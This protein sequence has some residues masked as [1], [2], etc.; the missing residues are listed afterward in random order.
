MSQ[1][2]SDPYSVLGVPADAT[3]EQIRKAYRRKARATHPDQGGS[4]PEFHE[5]SEA[6]RLL[7]DSSLKQT[8][9]H[10]SSN[11]SAPQATPTRPG[12]TQATRSPTRP[13]ARVFSTTPTFR[14]PFDPNTP[15]IVPLV[16]AGQQS[17]SA[18]RRPSMLARLS[19]TKLA[20][21]D[22]EERTAQLLE[23]TILKDYP[24]GRLINGVQFQNGTEAGSILLG[25]YRVAVV[26]SLIASA[27]A[28]RWDGG[29]LLHK[30]RSAGGPALR[31]TVRS[32]QELLPGCHVSGWLVL[33]N[34]KGNPFEPVIDYPPS[35]DRSAFAP[36]HAVNAGT[37]SR[38]LRQFMSAGPQPNVVQLPVL[39][40]LLEAT[41]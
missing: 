37:L 24:A 34:L 36:V 15:P 39:A 32:V 38:Q 2:E 25:G 22:A 28:Y 19:S 3:V 35:A 14:P 11:Q 40:R 16:V 1:T 20:T 41:T 29:R 23:S 26:A 9:D 6:Y 10:K 33:H 30:G 12:K 31:E 8:F 21:Y 17:H 7:T 5:V 13:E 18:P 27:P 4:A